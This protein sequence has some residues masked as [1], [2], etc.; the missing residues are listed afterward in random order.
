MD[1]AQTTTTTAV[2][3][4][5]PP[6]TAPAGGWGKFELQ[7]CPT[8]PAGSCFTQDCI[9]VNSP[10]TPT[11]CSV[12]GLNSGTSYSVRATAVQGSTTS[13]QSQAATFKTEGK[14]LER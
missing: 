7:I 4:V 14:R 11:T 5:T 6:T 13:E 2:A 3:T 12:T 1:N 9:P 10:P 8:S